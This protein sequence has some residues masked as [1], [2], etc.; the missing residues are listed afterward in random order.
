MRIWAVTDAAGTVIE[1]H[2]AT[3]DPDDCMAD[4][5]GRAREAGNGIAIIEADAISVGK[6][7]PSD[8]IRLAVY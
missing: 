6:P 4:W 7:L 1:A 3:G 2:I 8:C 5:L